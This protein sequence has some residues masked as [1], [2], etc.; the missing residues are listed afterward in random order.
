MF[1]NQPLSP[2]DP[3]T[4]F[5]SGSGAT[6]L[7]SSG[8]GGNIGFNPSAMQQLRS[9]LTFRSNLDNVLLRNSIG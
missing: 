4:R 5:D 3:Y 2:N 8:S 9:S 1:S 7:R 6:G